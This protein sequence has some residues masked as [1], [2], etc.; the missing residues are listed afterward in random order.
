[1]ANRN[2]RVAYRK[3]SSMSSQVY[4]LLQKIPDN[5]LKL[6]VQAVLRQDKAELERVAKAVGADLDVIEYML[7]SEAAN[8]WL[9]SQV[10]KP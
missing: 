6:A 4:Q 9:N 8:R 7:I 2:G 10:G 1:M 5:V 3:E